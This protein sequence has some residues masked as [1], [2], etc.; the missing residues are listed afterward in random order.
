MRK[1]IAIIGGWIISVALFYF[2]LR[3]I[4]L[5]TLVSQ[6]E[7]IQVLPLICALLINLLV[8]VAKSAR[9]FWLTPIEQRATFKQTNEAT[10]IGMTGNNLLPARAGD[11]LKVFLLNRCSDL[12][13][14]GLLSIV[15]LEKLF[16]ISTIIA[17][18]IYIIVSAATPAWVGMGLKT[19][20]IIFL[21]CVAA[22]IFLITT[23]KKD[24]LPKKIQSVFTNLASGLESLKNWRQV[25]FVF[26]FS[27]LISFLQIMTLILC[28]KAFGLSLPI[29]TPMLVFL[30]INVAIII[31]SAPSNLGPF[32][33]AAVL[34]Y[35]AFGINKEY[36]LN[37][38]LVYHVIQVIPVTLI[39]LFFITKNHIHIFK[40]SEI[41]T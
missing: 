12:S 14:L 16:D 31:P 37:V 8:V 20:I 15:G 33:F 40:Q 1:K 34:A 9:W 19:L 5:S 26:L 6:L 3:N 4:D 24:F 36:A 32:E 35:A 27:F 29:M 38:S 18:A 28:Q 17:F 41:T 30:A 10:F 25:S 2:L 22:I 21:C 39:G 13:K 7:R 11:I 23:A